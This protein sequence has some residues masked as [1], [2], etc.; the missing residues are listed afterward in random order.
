MPA[1]VPVP[2]RPRRDGW[3]VA[4]QAAFLA[5]LS[6]TR[7]VRRAAAHVG[8]SRESA[9]RL[10]RRPGA[11]SFAAAWD[12]IIHN[13]GQV[14]HRKVTHAEC[15]FR[16]IHGLIRPLLYRG[17]HVANRLITD[18]SAL[19]RHLRALD[20]NAPPEEAL[21]PR[22]HYAPASTPPAPRAGP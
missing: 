7:N 2:T 6:R 17:R 11:E 22:Y 10:R 14:Q 8:L 9:Y 3:S 21:Y 1:F 12:A 15:A 4:R 18:N 19:L 5:M 16:A 13:F 20:R